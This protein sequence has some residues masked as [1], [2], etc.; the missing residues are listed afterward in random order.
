MKIGSNQEG[1]TKEGLRERAFN[2]EQMANKKFREVRVHVEAKEFNDEEMSVV[3]EAARYCL[4]TVF[5]EFA[6]Y[7]DLTDEY[8][9]TIRE[10]LENV[11]EGVG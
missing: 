1:M 4:G 3:F 8:L 9:V 2:I 6:V 5:T 10:K 11:T 7:A